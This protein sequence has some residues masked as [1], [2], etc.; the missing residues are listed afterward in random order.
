MASETERQSAVPVQRMVRLRPWESHEIDLPPE[1]WKEELRKAWDAL[2]AHDL[3]REPLEKRAN[4]LEH[5]SFYHRSMMRAR[6]PE[7][8]EAMYRD[9]RQEPNK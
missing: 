8:Y 6:Y 1:T 5:S 2:R 9:D 4:E 7:S 3:A